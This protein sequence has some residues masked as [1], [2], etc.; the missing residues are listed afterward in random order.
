MQNKKIGNVLL[1][2]QDGADLETAAESE[3]DRQLL[4]IVQSYE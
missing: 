1:Y 4:E 2:C 3:D